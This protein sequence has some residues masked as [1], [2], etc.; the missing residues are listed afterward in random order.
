MALVKAE[1]FPGE[2][3]P[4]TPM[5]FAKP[6]Y[7]AT[8]KVFV[9]EVVEGPRYEIHKDETISAPQATEV[10]KGLGPAF[11]PTLI[12]AT[13][14]WFTKPLTV[15]WL[16]P[17]IQHKIADVA[18]DFEGTCTWQLSR[19]TISKEVFLFDWAMVSQVPDEKVLIRL[20]DDEL[21]A[22]TEDLRE[23]REIPSVE[24]EAV[25]VGP[26]RRMLHKR[27]VLRQRAKAARMLFKA[28]RM[29]QE[30]C[31]LYGAEDTDWEEEDSD[32]EDSD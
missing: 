28:E 1:F 14:T 4:Q 31:S 9:S 21:P 20:E 16:T 2:K 15:E 19:L 6:T 30:Y 23:V 26:T 27:E 17:R 5:K 7:N 10:S 11:I 13:K 12:Q 3:P 8:N 29:T 24:G 18:S 22:E 32:S 25:A